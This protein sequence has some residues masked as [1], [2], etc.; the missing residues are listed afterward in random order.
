M[1]EHNQLQVILT[2][3]NVAQE[4]AKALIKAFGA[5]FEEAGEIL[6]DYKSILVTGEDQFDLMA[7]ARDKRLTLKR[8]RTGVE[9]KRKELKEDALRTGKAI[10]GVAKYIKDT[11]QPAEEYLELQEKFA[12]TKRAEEAARVKAERIEKLQ[13][14]NV[15]LSLYNLDGMAQEQFD[16]LLSGLEA[17]RQQRVADEKAEAE[18]LAKV[19][20]DRIAEDKRVR[21]ENER[22]KKE[23]EDRE[24]E[25]EKQRKVEQKEREAEQAKRDEEVA[26]ERAKAEAERLKREQLE[27]EQREKD[28]EAERVKSE[29]NAR[30][31]KALLAPDKEKLLAFAVQIEAIQPPNVSNRDA[32]KVLDETMDFLERI[33]KNLRNKAKEL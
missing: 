1:A 22:L 13:P 32:G 23:R 31:A 15:D 24:A 11:I 5:P 20:A 28:T 9:N 21:E 8:I 10:D 27:R 3:Q 17:Q 2:E 25:L 14:Y 29:E 30:I 6:A 19:E 26:A 16:T 33:S 12:E 4:N 18:R 7:E